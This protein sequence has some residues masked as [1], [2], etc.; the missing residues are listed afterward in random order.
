L[1]NTRARLARMYGNEQALEL[2][3]AEGGG[4]LATLRIP[5]RPGAGDGSAGEARALA[6]EAEAVLR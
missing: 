2:G 5:F 6:A 1:G 3:D 4:A